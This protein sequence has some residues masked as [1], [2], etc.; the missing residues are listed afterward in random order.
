M[1]RTFCQKI[2]RI[3]YFRIG[4]ITFLFIIPQNVTEFRRQWFRGQVIIA[5]IQAKIGH[6]FILFRV[7]RIPDTLVRHFSLQIRFRELTGRLH[8]STKIVQ[9]KRFQPVNASFIEN[10][11]PNERQ[12]RLQRFVFFF[13][14]VQS[15]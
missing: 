2:R 5:S 10:L 15:I 6:I 3:R 14:S 13:F 12:K 1:Q 8:A 9:I 11:E 4:I 7:R